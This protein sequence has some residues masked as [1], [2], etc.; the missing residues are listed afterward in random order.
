METKNVCGENLML[1]ITLMLILAVN[2]GV[3]TG[4]ILYSAWQTAKLDQLLGFAQKLW[5][6]PFIT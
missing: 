3:F 4:T 1:A 2:G 5:T 6:L